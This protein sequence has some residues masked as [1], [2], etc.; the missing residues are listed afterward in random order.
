M[1][2]NILLLTI[3]LTLLTSFVPHIFTNSITLAQ[4]NESFDRVL[5][6][7]S[8]VVIKFWMPG[9]PPCKT[10]APRF[11]TASN[12]VFSKP[13]LFLTVNVREYP[14]IAT[15]YGIKSVPQIIYIKNG[16]IVGKQTGGS[17]STAQIQSQITSSFGI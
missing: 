15:R 9:C 4:T 17:T 12:T 1:K 13:V 3:G 2:K 16:T 7:N 10:L 6:D 11:E 5:A 14:T 8:N